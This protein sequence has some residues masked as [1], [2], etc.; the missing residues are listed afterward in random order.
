M[1]KLVRVKLFFTGIIWVVIYYLG[2]NLFSLVGGKLLLTLEGEGYLLDYKGYGVGVIKFNQVFTFNHLGLTA[3]YAIKHVLTIESKELV[4]KI[5][6][7]ISKG[8]K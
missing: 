6:Q 1:N 8:G 7:K 3:V 4:K 5:K 2:I